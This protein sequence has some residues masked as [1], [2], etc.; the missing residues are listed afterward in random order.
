MVKSHKR[1]AKFE[2]QKNRSKGQGH[3]DRIT[4][5]KNDCFLAVTS[6]DFDELWKDGIKLS[7]EG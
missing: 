1:K 3:R 6:T 5:L 2:S 4:F 7:K